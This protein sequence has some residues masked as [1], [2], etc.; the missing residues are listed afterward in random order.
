MFV[1]WPITIYKAS[2]VGDP[3]AE[4]HEVWCERLPTGEVNV[5]NKHG[6]WDDQE[7]HPHYSAPV[8]SE[9]FKDEGGAIM[10]Y[11]KRLNELAAQGF[12]Y[13]LTSVYDNA[14]SS[15]R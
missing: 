1:R 12:T 3:F 5:G 11:D 15:W 14:T 8:Y 2:P 4:W 7:K 9:L 13:K 6:W 10:E